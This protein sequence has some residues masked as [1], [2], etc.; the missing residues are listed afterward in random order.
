MSRSRWQVLALSL[1]RVGAMLV[2]LVAT[3]AVL[4]SG[5]SPANA[6][7]GPSVTGVEVTSNPGEGDTYALGEII[8]V[9]VTFSEAVDVTGTPQISIDMDPAAWGEKQAGYESGAG[10]NRVTFAHTVVEPNFSTQGVAVLAN[11]L[12]LN[13]GTIKS[14]VSQTAATLSHTGLGHDSGHKV[15]WRQSPPAPSVAGVAVT[16]DPAG[17]DTYALGETIEV[18]V[19]FTQA[20]D[21]TGTPQIS[22]DMDPAEWGEKQAGYESG[23][24]KA[25]L[26]FTHS[27]VE[28]NISTQGIAVL[29]NSLALNGGTIK[30]AVS[31][32]AAALS[33]TGLA[34][35]SSHKVN[36]QKTASTPTPAT[37][38]AVSSVAITSNPGGDDTYARD[39]VIKITVTF[40]EAVDVTGTPQIS[41]DM[42]PADWGEKQAGYHEGTGSTALVFTYTVV[43]PNI[44]TQG[45]AVLADS[46][47]LNGGSI[48]SASSQTAASL[49]H[50]GLTHDSSHKVD[51]QLSPPECS[52]TAPSSV[53]ALGV[54]RGAVVT[55]TLPADMS[56]A[57]QVTGFVISGDHSA[58]GGLVTGTMTPVVVTDP[59]A[60]TYTIRGLDPGGWRFSVQITYGE[61]TSDDFTTMLSTH[62]PADCSITLTVAAD[63]TLAI[64]GSWTNAGGGETGCESGGVR[65]DFKKTADPDWM[66]YMTQPD[67]EE[68][69]KAFIIGGLEYGVSYSFRVVATDAA[70]ATN[71]SAT[72]TATAGDGTGGATSTAGAPRNVRVEPNIFLGMSVWW[73]APSSTPTGTTVNGYYVEYKATTDATW[74]RAATGTTGNL[75]AS[76][77]SVLHN[78]LHTVSNDTDD[79]GIGKLDKNK[80]YRVRVVTEL[81]DTSSPPNKT[82]VN[83]APTG[84]VRPVEDIQLWWIDDTPNNNPD[85]GRVFMMV[86]S[87]YGSA[88]GV[89]CHVSGVS[90]V[91]CPPRTLT[92]LDS[93]S[94]GPSHAIWSTGTGVAGASVRAVPATY[95]VTGGQGSHHP[96]SYVLTSAGDSRFLVRW[97]PQTWPYAGMKGWN[98]DVRSRV[99]GAWTDWETRATV[100]ADAREAV[101]TGMRNDVG[102]EARVRMRRINSCDHDNDNM[103]PDE[104]N[105][106][107]CGV[108]LGQWAAYGVTTAAGKTRTPGHVT[109][110]K[111]TKAGTQLTVSWDPPGLW[112]DG[113]EDVYGYKIRH[114]ATGMS[115]WQEQE[116][117][118]RKYWRRCGGN[119]VCTNPRTVTISG[120]ATT[121][122]YAVQV[123]ALNVNGTGQ[124]TDL[125]TSASAPAPPADPAPPQPAGA[126]VVS[127]ATVADR[128]LTVTLADDVYGCP[129]GMAFKITHDGETSRAVGSRCDGQT[130]RIHLRNSIHS[131][132]VTLAYTAVEASWNGR[133]KLYFNGLAVADFSGVAVSHE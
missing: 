124:W 8:R 88:S 66:T 103:T 121:A 112:P 119:G 11:S 101:I 86:D 110:G 76:T 48:K 92:S 38:P 75:L 2:V 10:S 77:V 87:N 90:P 102:H 120:V 32:T 16:S 19:A 130:I 107:A 56:D 133:T 24:G 25:R 125:A 85:I 95:G 15:D 50:S 30:S 39:D 12:A 4:W 122:Q 106:A 13:G 70:G 43:E 14:A 79:T 59:E 21:V 127:S 5:G 100:D 55:W 108:G 9:T 93:A 23:T 117:Y 26:V 89:V 131:G 65:I 28:P 72:A 99:D 1:R 31:Q 44:S 62:V 113:G 61:R 73:D 81:V 68:R 34:H 46:L 97:A 41:I 6:A 29:A 22:I 126:E 54:E 104:R 116:F 47:A 111:A 71:T 78:N 129:A 91:N 18:A 37:T 45:I 7:G 53:S 114:W 3:L 118:H 33:H 98:V 64:S 105:E 67:H 58:E 69:A 128:I 27:V 17:G 83:S 51:W 49:S 74:T 96:V 82:T 115:A 35:D 60:R 20:V 63:E 40:S 84:Q 57:C 109:N 123:A 94:V 132:E 52:L 42:D 80:H 36:W